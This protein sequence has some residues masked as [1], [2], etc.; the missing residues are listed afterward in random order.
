MV[1][2]FR[3]ELDG[4]ERIGE[5]VH[6]YGFDITHEGAYDKVWWAPGAFVT[7][8]FL[9][10]VELPLLTPSP[11]FMDT[12]PLYLKGRHTETVH[13]ED[14]EEL[15][16][17]KLKGHRVFVKLPLAKVDSCPARVYSHDCLL[18]ETFKQYNFHPK[19][20]LSVQKEL[21]FDIEI[22]FFMAYGKAVS[23]SFYKINEFIWGSEEFNP[24]AT[25]YSYLARMAQDVAEEACR[26]SSFDLP[27]GFVIDVGFSK[28]HP[29][30]VVIEANASWSSSPYACSKEG[31][32]TSVLAAHDYNREH[33]DLWWD[34]QSNPVF[35]NSKPLRVNT[36]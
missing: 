30:P 4:E 11:T 19:T 8:A 25:Q 9:A 23:G 5:I 31:M 20:L 15:W 18:P 6:D 22:R 16:E 14:L 35:A 10:G 36:R 24:L 13:L 26:V 33:R 12:L 29:R 3:G 32:L 7:S 1:E 34:M 21:Q 17:L 28:S 2:E 27:H